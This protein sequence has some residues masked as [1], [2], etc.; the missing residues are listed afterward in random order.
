MMSFSITFPGQ[1]EASHHIILLLVGC[2]TCTSIG[3]LD[4]PTSKLLASLTNGLQ[5]PCPRDFMLVF[6]FAIIFYIDIGSPL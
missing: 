6:E 4:F 1:D 2:C 3:H 5:M